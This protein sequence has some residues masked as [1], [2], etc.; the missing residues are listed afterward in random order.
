M[1]KKIQPKHQYIEPQFFKH[2]KALRHTFESKFKNPRAVPSHRFVWDYWH[3]ENQYTALRTP[4]RHYFKA[5]DYKKLEAALL[6]YGKNV[7]GCSGLSEPWLSLYIDGCEQKVHA[8]NPH[9]PWAYVYSLTPWKT[10]EFK[11]G[12]TLIST[13]RLLNYWQTLPNTD[14]GFEFDDFFNPVAPEF[15]QLLVFDPRLPHG[16]KRVEGVREPTLGR[17][18]VHGWFTEPVPFIDGSLSANDKVFR[19]AESVLSQSLENLYKTWNSQQ[20]LHGTFTVRMKIN[21]QGK[22][23]K[24]TILSNTLINRHA[25]TTST[26]EVRKILNQIETEFKKM[27][28]PIT[29]GSSLLTVPFLFR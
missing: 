23:S 2:A 24:P 16:V 9:G 3:I 22:T 4:A 21:P 1:N 28:F 10:R 26:Q 6:D 27:T 14:R 8:D 15:N 29:R 18:V 5:Q 11:G 13:P 20:A 19:T 25:I 12:E 17:L 7:L